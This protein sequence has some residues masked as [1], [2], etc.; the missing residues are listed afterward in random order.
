MEVGKVFVFA[1]DVAWFD[2]EE[3][4]IAQN[5]HDEEYEHQQDEHIEEG[6][7]RHHNRLKQGL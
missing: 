1:D 6:L 2:T 5:G 4:G 7:Y 3:Q